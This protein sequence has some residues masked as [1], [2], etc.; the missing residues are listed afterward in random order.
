MRLIGAKLFALSLLLLVNA[1]AQ[2]GEYREHRVY[3]RDFGGGHGGQ[4]MTEA[5]CGPR[6][7]AT[8]FHAQIGKYF[9]QV[10]ADCAE[11]R[12][13]GEIERDVRV[14][15]RAGTPGGNEVQDARCRFGLVM[16]GLRGR[17]GGSVDQAAGICVDPRDLDRR[18]DRR[19]ELTNT[20]SIPNP[21]GNPIEAVCEPGHVMVGFRTKNGQWIDHL[22]ILCA[23]VR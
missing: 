22:W 16:I 2:E 9:N 3:E 6:S 8:G 19:V 4:V 12:R 18:E 11:L 13:N 7:A 14:S 21:D 23:D 5:V 10:W 1:G 17:T 20:V 15:D